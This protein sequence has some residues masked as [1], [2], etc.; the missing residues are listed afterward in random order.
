MTDLSVALAKLPPEKAAALLAKVKQ[1]LQKKH[2]YSLFPDEG[3]LRR[4]LYAKHVEFMAHGATKNERAFI[5][6]NRIGKTVCAAFELSCHLLGYYPD[7]WTGRRFNRP[8]VAW[9]CGED[10]KAMRESIQPVLLGY[11]I[12]PMGT[13]T[14][15]AESI[16]GDPTKRAGVPEGIDSLGIRHSS[17][18]ISRLVMK[19]F[20]QGRESY[21]GAKVDV[22]WFDEEPPSPIYSE[23]FTRTM[24]TVPGEENGV[25]MCTFTPLKG[26]SS[27]V[28]LYMPG[29]RIVNEG[30]R[31]AIQAT[32]SDVP[33]LSEEAK[34]AVLESYLPS[35]RSARSQGIPQF[36]SGLIFPVPEEDI[37]CAPFELPAWYRFAYGL[38]VGWNRTAAVWSARNPETDVVYLY[39]EY[40]RGQAEPAVHAQGIK[41]PGL[42]I[43][44]VIDPSAAGAGKQRD[45]EGILSM[46]V[47]AGLNLTSADN[48]V[49]AGLYEV[50]SRLSSGRLK[51]FNTL[52]NWLNEFR[53][54]RRDEKGKVVKD[55]DH[56][57]D[58]TRYLIMSGLAR[59][60]A[61]PYENW[62]AP[63]S[64]SRHTFEFDPF[65]EAYKTSATLQ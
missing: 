65:A 27:V 5:A 49:E 26:L 64:N 16:V 19:T 43:P 14:I 8:I 20:D 1:S 25:V 55:N 24:A 21:Q 60:R 4:E 63:R 51:V 59:D 58:A 41:A 45:G 36:G 11:P 47:A 31:W 3:P 9:A 61:K 53:I 22:V 12:S 23:G 2:L 48:R 10:A 50:W 15:P 56:L 62:P 38:D 37:T 18:G 42:W 34:K 52:S 13:G 17:G 57:L 30:S 39:H 54:Y 29:G 32:W 40:Y 46:Y 7:W 35:E 33:H 44:G 28:Q 6:A